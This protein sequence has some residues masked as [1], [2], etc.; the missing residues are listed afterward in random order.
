MKNNLFD[1]PD[2]ST[3][4]PLGFLKYTQPDSANPKFSRQHNI[5]IPPDL[6]NQLRILDNQG[7]STASLFFHETTTTS[8]VIVHRSLNDI[9]PNYCLI[10]GKNKLGTNNYS[11]AQ[12]AI[13][14]TEDSCERRFVKYFIATPHTP[15]SSLEL[16]S[17]E[18]KIHNILHSHEKI[19]TLFFEI[20][21]NPVSFPNKEVI[22][23]IDQP[24]YEGYDMI[25]Y[26]NQITCTTPMAMQLS[27]LSLC[28]LYR[29]H[30]V[31]SIEHFDIKPEHFFYDTVAK[32]IR[33]IDFGFSNFFS[34]ARPWGRGTFE[35]MA[36][37]ILKPCQGKNPTPGKSDIFS[38]GLTLLAL[39]NHIKFYKDRGKLFQTL[40]P[41]HTHNKCHPIQKKSSES[42][43]KENNLPKAPPFQLLSFAKKK[44]YFSDFGLQDLQYILY[45]KDYL[46]F[47]SHLVFNMLQDNPHQRPD[48]TWV[49]YEYLGYLIRVNDSIR[50]KLPWATQDLNHLLLSTRHSV[51]NT[52]HKDKRFDSIITYLRNLT[53]T[54]PPVDDTKYISPSLE[55]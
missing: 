39:H 4:A 45:K 55:N 51:L 42:V 16:F 41:S 18:M 22:L 10:L 3:S 25:H 47:L 43:E 12:A 24:F 50:H 7:Y 5:T 53:P 49:L 30:T 2:Y 32:E 54:V 17:Q 27:L 37:E 28:A 23:V 33:I 31:Y 13:K 36:P 20:S 19:P 29:L 26:Y 38:M 15:P 40:F 9:L 46:V 34:A 14:I 6:M 52:I 48:I 21:P 1:L 8:A 44:I 11:R 35:Y